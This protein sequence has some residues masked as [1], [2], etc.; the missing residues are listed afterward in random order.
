M[1]QKTNEKNQPMVLLFMDYSRAFD[2][3]KHTLMWKVLDRIGIPP[4]IMNIT[5]ALY[6]NQKGTVHINNQYSKEFPTMQG[7][8]QGCVLSPHILIPKRGISRS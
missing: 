3:V 4:H 5:E 1:I 7:V 8:R 6:E 2:C